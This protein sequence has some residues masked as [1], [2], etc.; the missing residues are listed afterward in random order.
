MRY[1]ITMWRRAVTF[2]V[3]V[4]GVAAT[5]IFLPSLPAD[6]ASN[7]P[8]AS[9]SSTT[10]TSSTTA[11][12]LA[13]VLRYGD[14]GPLVRTLQR[15]LSALGYW[16]GHIDGQFGGLTQQAVFALQKAASLSVDGVVGVATTAAL[17]RGIRPRVR[18][19]QGSEVQINLQ[20][21]LLMIMRN[22][23]LAS[24]LNTSTGGGY[25]YTS[26]GVTSIATTPR[27]VF[28][29][30]RQ[31]DAMDISPLGQLWRPKYFSGGYAIHGSDSVPPVAVSHGCVRLSNRAMD[32]IWASNQM[33][34]GTTVRIY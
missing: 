28:R 14:R 13:P 8:H 15:R 23:K 31:V 26:G 17:S 24:T 11:T 20:T 5:S 19:A 30:T 29:I 21:Q 4:A 25:Y 6:A 3:L 27:G 34:I 10:I 1:P 32:W 2:R 33:P 7:V 22:G 12:R 16:D 9:S 18:A